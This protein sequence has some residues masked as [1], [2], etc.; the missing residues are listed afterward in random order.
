[1]KVYMYKEYNDGLAYGEEYIRLFYNKA[2]AEALLA[3]RVEEDYH[4]HI[5]VMA[6]IPDF[7]YDVIQSDYVS[8]KNGEDTAYYIIEEK[9]VEGVESSDNK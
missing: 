4:M 7:K 5:S 6:V 8:I 9:E 2:D 3:K 1:M